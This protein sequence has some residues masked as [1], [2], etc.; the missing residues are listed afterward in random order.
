MRVKLNGFALGLILALATILLIILGN[1]KEKKGKVEIPVLTPI[2][3]ESKLVPS[4]D[5]LTVIEGIGPKTHALLKQYGIT[6]FALLAATEIPFLEKILREKGWQFAKPKSWPVQAS[7]VAT[8]K[9]DELKEL[10]AKLIA[11][12]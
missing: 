4:E 6:T 7:L 2:G 8:G 12:R 10:Q 11:G 3:S 9:L 5:D 1:K